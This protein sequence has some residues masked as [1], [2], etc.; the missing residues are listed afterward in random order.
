M[1]S[2]RIKGITVEIGG[3]TTKLD[4]ALKDS[5]KTISDTQKGLKDVEKLLKLDPKNVE[6][7]EQKQRLLAEATSA[8]SEKLRVLRSAAEQADEAL[9]R[10]Q[11][12]NE[13]Y[14]PLKASLDEVGARLQSL[15]SQNEAVNESLAS[16]KIS[17][18]EFEKF[19]NTLQTTQTEY[20]ALLK[21]KTD[22]DNEFQGS[23]LNQ[24]Q[25]DAL[26]RELSETEVAAREAE[27][28]FK[29]FNP[30]LEEFS[31]NAKEV[32]SKADSV[33]NATKKLSAGAAVAAAGLVG[34]AV[35]AGLAA[36]DLNTLAAQSGF[37]T[38]LIQQWQYASDRIDVS[39]DTIISAAQKMKKN[40]NST[41]TEVQSAWDRLGISVRD[42]SG[43]FRDA[44]VVFDE[45]L[46]RLSQIPNETER[47]VLAMTLFG[48][49]AD[50]LAGLIDD[51]GAALREM[52][53]EAKDAGL[54]LSQDALDGANAFNDGID[55]LKAKASAAFMEAG[56]SLATSL[57]PALSDLVDIMS[58][59][60]EFIGSLDGRILKFILTITM[61]VATI[62]PIAKAI[63]SISTAV[64]GITKVAN[65]FSATAGNSVYAT[66]LKW[67]I[68][69]IAVVAAIT[70]LI[71]V[72]SV[73]T[74]K[75]QEVNQT[76]GNLSQVGSSSIGSVTGA[77]TSPRTRSAPLAASLD[78]LPA[79]ANGG[80]FMPNHPFIG[81]LGDNQS[82]KEIAAPES[83]LKS[84]FEDVLNSRGSGG[85]LYATLQVD[86]V[87]FARLVTPYMD[88]ENMRRG[89]SLVEG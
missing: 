82:E 83:T 6:L 84:T 27:K 22:L 28:A 66:F 64:S 65:L 36:D 63:S 45:V 20:D 69:I 19:N 2:N 68:I 32:A 61:I 89:V 37:S 29:D 3:D 56:A 38:E 24:S 23:K 10:G 59:V 67:S 33:Y 31:A 72:I 86:G 50:E 14:A 81:V 30:T 26:Q 55:M 17:T 35:K 87:T 41:S 44:D 1:A 42:G 70:A 15:K 52:G 4:K 85:T 47:D 16:G 76:L 80:V 49:K 77:G 18:D 58:R 46:Q 43:Q 74:G 53:Q 13:K 5:N 60:L 7:L 39:V 62:A 57:I 71:A 88:R 8:S 12:Y 9:A 21:A 40:M 25:Y 78:D 73:L 48:K 34:M 51:G 11:A 75:G 79:F 54:I